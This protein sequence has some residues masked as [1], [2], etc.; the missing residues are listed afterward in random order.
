LGL[1]RPVVVGHSWATLVALVLG[2]DSPR[3]S[4]AWSCSRDTTIRLS[5]RCAV[6]LTTGSA[7]YRSAPALVGLAPYRPHHLPGCPKARIRARSSFRA[8]L[9]RFP[10]RVS[11]AA[12]SACGKRRRHR[13]DD[14]LSGPPASALQP[15]CCS[16]LRRGWDRRPHRR[17]GP[18]IGSIGT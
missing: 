17:S 5:I 11:V 16:R 3:Q 15:A 12:Q 14:P 10:A 7:D 13:T 18:A 4:A 2:L 1:V 6:P 8:L 9:G